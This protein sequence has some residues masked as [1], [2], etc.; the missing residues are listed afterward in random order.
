MDTNGHELLV[1]IGVHS[2]LQLQNRNGYGA[3]EAVSTM[4]K[5]D[6]QMNARPRD[7]GRFGGK[8]NYPPADFAEDGRSVPE[9]GPDDL[10]RLE[11]L[12]LEGHLAGAV[13][14]TR[15]G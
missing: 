6:G 9:D 4:K 7:G 13:G 10:R 8:L 14:A 5:R 11:D 2:W 12:D 1:F 15:P 3:L